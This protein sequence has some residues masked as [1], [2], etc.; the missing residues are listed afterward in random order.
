M[1]HD[2]TNRFNTPASFQNGQFCLVS[3]KI[4]YTWL[5]YFF[6]SLAL[7][8]KSPSFEGSNIFL[9]SLFQKDLLFFQFYLLIFSYRLIIASHLRIIQLINFYKQTKTSFHVF[10]FVLNSSHKS[11]FYLLISA[12][13]M[14]ELSVYVKIFH[15]FL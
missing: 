12:F 7:T 3:W 14:L 10:I 15:F 4:Q 1:L 6:V 11:S 5:V 2:W 13:N 9:V 8:K